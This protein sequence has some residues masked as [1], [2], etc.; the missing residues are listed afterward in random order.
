MPLATLLRSS[1]VLF[2]PSTTATF[3]VAML[4]PDIS[5][6]VTTA[7]PLSVELNS[8]FIIPVVGFGFT[9]NPPLVSVN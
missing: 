7:L 8:M 3:C 2:W 5:S 4:R 9:A 6:T 1:W